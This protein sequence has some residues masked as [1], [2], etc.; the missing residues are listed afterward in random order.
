MIEKILARYINEQDYIYGFANIKGLLSG[1][2]QNY[3][4]GI[5]IG[6][7]LDDE[8]L[9]EVKNG[10]TKVYYD[11]YRNFN[12]ELKELAI[13]VSNDLSEAGI[14]A[15]S[16]EPSLGDSNLN[17][18]EQSLTLDIS[19]KM[20]ATRA[21]LGWIGKTA[22]FI[23]EKFGPRLR[24]VSILTNTALDY[25]K[26]PI[27]ESKCG[28]CTICIDECPAGAAKDILWNINIHRD[29][30]F[31]AFKCREMCH[32]LGKE[33]LGFDGHICGICVAVCPFGC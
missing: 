4:Y 3:D 23:S 11:L 10:P 25:C 19:H 13:K 22:L 6:R 12:I 20:L 16:T 28:N 18:Y 1:I 33:R 32:K 24:F 31:D 21:G 30:F 7:K 29:Q 5:V 15:I 2:Y 9:D 27:T 26:T 17:E 8:I 14:K